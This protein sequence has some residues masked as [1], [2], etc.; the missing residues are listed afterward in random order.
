[1]KKKYVDQF[2]QRFD[3]PRDY[4]QNGK[5]YTWEYP[6][7]LINRLD[8]LFIKEQVDTIICEG[9]IVEMLVIGDSLP[10]L[11]KIYRN[12]VDTWV[13]WSAK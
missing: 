13:S 3:L 11:E 2:C 1:M 5:F 9:P 8:I 6:N 7:M 4:K 10:I 12:T